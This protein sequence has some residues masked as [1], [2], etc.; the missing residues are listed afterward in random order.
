[1]IIDQRVTISAPTERVWDFMMD[2]PAVSRCLPGVETVTQV[3]SDTY[4][5]ALQVKVGPIAVR[6]E[7]RV[8]L[9]EQDADSRR[10]RMEL[11]AADKRVNGAVNARMLMQLHP[12]DDGQTD[13]AIH[14]DA[15]VMGKLGEFGQ[16]V[17]RKKA[18]QMVA[19][20][21][22]NLSAQVALPR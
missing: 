15:T 11:K 5:G 22:R 17:I 18:D 19:E 14:T 16:A 10:A 1:M 13:L 8:V 20:F 9:A 4:A 7:G 3:D 21:A 12:R 2:V 6:L